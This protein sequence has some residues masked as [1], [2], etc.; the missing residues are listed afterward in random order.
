MFNRP[1]E[2]Q[3]PNQQTR[4]SKG[5][6]I[7]A[8]QDTE[9]VLAWVEERIAAVTQL[10]RENGEPFNV[11][12]YEHMQHYDSHMDSFD[13]K[14]GVHSVALRAAAMGPEVVSSQLPQRSSSTA[15]GAALSSMH[16]AVTV[17]CGGPGCL[18]GHI[19]L[20]FRF[21]LG[22]HTRTSPFPHAGV[23]APAQPAHRHCAGLPVGCAGRWRD[24]VQ[25]RGH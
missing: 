14:V 7:G 10:P 21:H 13:P 15:H 16:R 8:P 18:V 19:N 24:G 3:D 17:P 11:L 4:T 2:D 12:Q 6:F 22:R 1:G 5:T 20:L 23:W 9:G 25:A